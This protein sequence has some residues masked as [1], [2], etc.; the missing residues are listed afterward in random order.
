MLRVVFC[1]IHSSGRVANDGTNTLKRAFI[2][3]VLNR[4][5][6][7]DKLSLTVCDSND[8]TCANPNCFRR[9]NIGTWDINHV[10]QAVVQVLHIRTKSCIGVSNKQF[11]TAD[12]ERICSSSI[13][14]I[15]DSYIIVRLLNLYFVN[16]SYRKVRE[17]QLVR[18]VRR[19]FRLPDNIC[20]TQPKYVLI[21]QIL[22]LFIV[23]GF[24]VSLCSH[25]ISRNIIIQL[26]RNDIKQESGLANRLMRSNAQVGISHIPSI[27]QLTISICS[28]E[29]AS[30]LCNHFHQFAPGYVGS[31]E[32]LNGIITVNRS[33]VCKFKAAFSGKLSCERR[34]ADR[35][36]KRIEPV[37]NINVKLSDIVVSSNFVLVAT[38]FLRLLTSE[39]AD[40]CLNC[41]IIINFVVSQLCSL[42]NFQGVIRPNPKADINC[43]G[44]YSA[45]R[46]VIAIRV[47]L[48]SPANANDVVI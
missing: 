42:R 8:S 22:L 21:I 20:R 9:L 33:T 12:N 26:T 16:R 19:A 24:V 11:I 6:P 38:V 37:G 41:C 39:H 7:S 46:N 23:C 14:R 44:T 32:R 31:S 43:I 30:C 3:G 48:F 40:F 4:C 1:V 36:C 45:G 25:K 5:N 15:D 34:N 28:D 29:R 27:L 35:E 13:T 2:A 17:C 10:V 18:E 47:Y